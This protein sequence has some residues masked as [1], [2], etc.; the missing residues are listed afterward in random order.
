V[1]VEN[2]RAIERVR[3]I[4]D[5]VDNLILDS[6]DPSTGRV[7]GTGIAHDWSISAKIVAIS[8]VPVILAGGLTPENVSEAIAECDGWSSSEA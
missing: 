6:T 8:K 2:E 1:S 5:L 3:A 7:G 4:E